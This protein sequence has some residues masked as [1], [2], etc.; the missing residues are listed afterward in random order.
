M[1]TALATKDWEI[2]SSVADVAVAFDWTDFAADLDAAYGDFTGEEDMNGRLEIV[3]A[4]GTIG[5]TTDLSILEKGL[6]DDEVIV[7]QYAAQSYQQ[8]TG[9]DVSS[10][11]RTEN[12]VTTPHAGA[13]RGERRGQ[14][15]R[16]HAETTRGTILLQMLPE[17]PLNA[18]NFVHLVESGFYDGLGF[19][20]VIPN[21]VAQGG[22]PRGDGSGG[23]RYLVRDELSSVAHTT[24]RTRWVSPPRGRTPGARSSSSTKGGT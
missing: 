10:Q 4:L 2:V 7:S 12:V 1:Q 6:A 3:Y 18:T 19:H 11:V 13:G 8:I 14:F 17:A 16:A 23:S 5:S 20:R 21:F 15:R 24:G 9:T 22:D